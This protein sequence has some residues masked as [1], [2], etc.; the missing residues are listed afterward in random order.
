MALQWGPWDFGTNIALLIVG[1][2][3]LTAAGLSLLTELF[4]KPAALAQTTAGSSALQSGGERWQPPDILKK[5]MWVL[6]YV[7]A[8]LALRHCMGAIGAIAL[9]AIVFLMLRK[10]SAASPGD[11]A[12][13]VQRELE[14]KIH[15]D[16]ASDTEH[17][18]LYTVVTRAARFFGYLIAF[19]AVMAV[20]G[21][22]P[23]VAIFVV[24]FMRLEGRERWSLVIPYA[25]LLV[26]SIYVAFHVFM[27]VP[28]PPTLLGSM[29]PA[30]KIIPSV[31]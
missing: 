2:V 11:Q 31:Q 8:F 29:F 24:V 3:A 15:M 10:G 16:L 7:V 28:W 17:L 23:T 19:M 5:S 4:R 21:L 9:L 6:A 27:S 26:L 22:I 13:G 12:K 14:Q 20:I 18:P 25:V 30:F 1:T